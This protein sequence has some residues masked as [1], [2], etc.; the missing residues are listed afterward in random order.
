MPERARRLVRA[1]LCAGIEVAQN[2]KE[3][4]RQAFE[5]VKS[6][7]TDAASETANQARSAA[8]DVRE[9]MQR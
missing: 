6:T 2:L 4:A 5:E 1:Q 8:D 7:A 9:P 3:P